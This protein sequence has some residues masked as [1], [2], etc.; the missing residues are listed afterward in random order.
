M[1]KYVVIIFIVLI[2]LILYLNRA[3]AHIF[4]FL[5]YN[6]PGNP[7]THTNFVFPSPIPNSPFKVT[8]VAL[9]DSLTA[10]VGA[11]LE[12]ESYPYRLAERLAES[13]G[14][15]VTLVNLGQPG[16]TARDVLNDQVP[17]VVALHPDVVTLAIGINDMHNGVSDQEFQKN[18]RGIVNS[19][20][21]TVKYLNVATIPFL[22]NKNAFWPPYR[23]YFDYQTQHYNNLLRGAMSGRKILFIDLYSLTRERALNDASYYSPDGFHASAKAYDFWSQIFYDHINY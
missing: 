8:Y 16:A 3:Y 9:G 14:A 17:Q 12:K 20:S 13:R 4:S 22:A 23:A 21:S 2:G 15:E 1:M 5:N 19:L 7:T 10:G 11:A 6:N 18:L